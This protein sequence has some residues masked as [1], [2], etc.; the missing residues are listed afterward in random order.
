M[1]INPDY[2]PCIKAVYFLP[3]CKIWPRNIKVGM[4]TRLWYH[5]VN[6]KIQTK[7]FYPGEIPR[8]D[9]NRKADSEDPDQTAQSDLG[10][11]CL[12]RPICPKTYD[13]YDM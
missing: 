5:N 13:H 4:F 3:C 9:A 1:L 2:L 7:R 6:S 11:D 12:P 8:K 10:L